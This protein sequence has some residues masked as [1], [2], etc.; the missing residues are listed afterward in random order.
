MLKTLLAASARPTTALHDGSRRV[1]S[2][3]GGE[4]TA[5][6]SSSS[7]RATARLALALTLKVTEVPMHRMPWTPWTPWTQR[8]P[9]APGDH[10]DT[11]DG[12][13]DGSSDG[14]S[15]CPASVRVAAA[16]ALALANAVW[17]SAFGG[18]QYRVV[19]PAFNFL[20][21]YVP[22]IGSDIALAATGVALRSR[23]DDDGGSNARVVAVLTAFG[24]PASLQRRGVGAAFLADIH[25]WLRTEVGALYA[26]LSIDREPRSRR[27][28]V[29]RFFRRAG[30]RLVN[31]AAGRPPDD[32]ADLAD[33]RALADVDWR[34][35]AVVHMMCKLA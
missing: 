31:E 6:S 12:G 5:S 29:E 3:A 4:T 24:V 11:D 20:C 32:R 25:E 18:P 35:P 26:F 17:P 21:V 10:S 30:Y 8:R 28:D 1:E 9:G 7:S 19:Q 34:D 23:V 13:S 22:K 27:A 14:G 16:H 2:E 33:L 15:D